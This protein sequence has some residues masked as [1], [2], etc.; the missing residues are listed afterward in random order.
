MIES[1]FWRK[2][3][4]RSGLAKLLPSI[5][6][7]LSGGEDFLHFY[8]DRTLA[9]PLTQLTDNALLPDIQT[10]DSINLASGAPRCD[11]NLDL[12]RAMHDGR[13]PDAWGDYE[14]RTELADQF[15]LE[16]GPEHDPAEEVLVTHGASGAFAAAID[17]Y[18]NPGN[19]VVLFDPTSPTFAVGFKHRRARIRWVK[20]WS[21]GGRLRFAMDQ[22]TKVMRGAKLL[23]V[24]DPANPTGCVLAPEDL[25]QIAFWAYKND[26]LI[27]QDSSFDRWRSEPAKGRLASLPHAERRILTCGSFAKSH[28]LTSIRV[29]WLMGDRHLVRPCAAAMALTAPFVSAVCQRI[30]LQ[31]LRTGEAAMS[32]LREELIGRQGYVREQLQEIGFKPWAALGGFFLWMPTLH[33][34]DD[35]QFAQRLLRDTGV[36]I[37]PGSPFGPSGK[38][39]V[40][41][42]YAIDE[43]R[44]R[45]GLTRLQR[46]IS[47]EPA[48]HLPVAQ[49]VG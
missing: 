38:G 1:F 11:L 26:V 21:E 45:E 35:R 32:A 27:F 8:S 17:A 31:A 19:T 37:N 43:G 47:R 20:T 40:R 30:A 33:G 12:R 3:L 10:P 6:R 9:L 42:S 15:Q 13:T 5:R 49:L 16:H 46:F 2:L 28:G 34:E 24:S 48:P 7:A 14:L 25:E 36:L 39:F 4:V 22:F 44:L 29:G 18:V 41:I 23:V